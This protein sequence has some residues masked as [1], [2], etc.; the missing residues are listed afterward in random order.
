MNLYS[1]P[2]R[3]YWVGQAYWMLGCRRS[4]DMLLDILNVTCNKLT[5]SCWLGEW[6]NAKWFQDFLMQ[7]VIDRGHRDRLEA[8][9]LVKHL[10]VSCKLSYCQS[11]WWKV[12]C[13]ILKCLNVW[14]NSGCKLFIQYYSKSHK[15]NIDGC[16]SL[17]IWIP[18]KV[19]L[20]LY[21]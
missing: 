16:I 18:P 6:T 15:V 17:Y 4:K 2:T 8:G 14:L 1:G 5:A 9:F 19:F 3:V 12:A 21:F 20:Y 13:D 7:G 10:Y 11:H